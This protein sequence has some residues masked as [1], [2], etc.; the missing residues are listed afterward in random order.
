MRKNN[1]IHLFDQRSNT[2]PAAPSPQQTIETETLC[3][4]W[5]WPACSLNT[6]AQTSSALA[7]G[8]TVAEYELHLASDLVKFA[9]EAQRLD[10]ELKPVWS[11]A[12]RVNLDLPTMLL[13]DFSVAGGEGLPVI[14]DA[15][16]A[17]HSAT[18]A[19][20]SDD[21]SLVRTLLNNG[22]KKVYVTDW[23][24]ATDEMKDFSIDTY[25]QDL[26]TAIDAVGGKA[27]L[28]GICQ[29]G[30]MSAAYAARF[31]GKVETLVLAGSPIDADAGEGSV[32]HLAHTLPMSFYNALVTAGGGRLL[33]KF[34]LAGWK[35]MNPTNQYI[36]KYLDLFSHIWDD[37]Y[38]KRAEEF[39][40][41]Y[42]TPQD[43]PGVY[44]L[45]AVEWLFKKNRLA[46]GSFVAL[47]HTITLRDIT[48]PIYMLA[49]D[50]DDITP[51]EQ[52]F[53][54]AHLVST[55][56][57]NM[58]QKS[59][60]GGHIGLFMGRTNLETVWP[61]IC[62]WIRAHDSTANQERTPQL[63]KVKSVP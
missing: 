13:R 44:Y 34:M 57:I 20:F 11:A 52:V 29:G 51:A 55:P 45:Q 22:L 27:H 1:V 62:Q 32:K 59:V 50:N 61:E 2:A 60:A 23:K 58:V 21:Q 36:T 18:I 47:G 7:I 9:Q 8:N 56:E 35:G 37:K 3:L 24:S 33:G 38:L 49:G 43:L 40:R 17:G 4:P 14:I 25:M 10:Y 15:P 42:E 48:I 30:W 19:D 53:N 46:T 31:I 5:L 39:A 28:I 12:N 41:W 26:D 54:A 6:M 63:T 16:F